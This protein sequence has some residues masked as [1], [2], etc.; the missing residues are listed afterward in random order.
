MKIST[1]KMW[2]LLVILAFTGVG[3]QDF[4]ATD[5]PDNELSFDEGIQTQQDLEEM[6]NSIYDVLANSLSGQGQKFAELLGQ[7]VNMVGN[8]GDDVQIYRRSTDFFNGSSGGWYRDPYFVIY[9]ANTL[10]EQIDRVGIDDVDRDRLVG[11]SY[12]LRAYAHLEL[13]KLFAQPY[14]YTDDN[15]H[16]GIVLRRATFTDPEPRSSVADVY[17][18]IIS[19]L[20]TARA[21]L[22]TLNPEGVRVD[23]CDVA[24]LLARVYLYQGQYAEAQLWANTAI[25]ESAKTLGAFG[26]RYVVGEQPQDALLY[27]VSTSLDDNRSGGWRGPFASDLGVPAVRA[28]FGISSLLADQPADLRRSTIDTLQD[29]GADVQVY[30]KYNML[31]FNSTLLSLTEMYYIEAESILRTSGDVN[32]AKELL[33]AIRLRNGLAELETNNPLVLLN[34]LLIDKRKEFLAEGINLWDLKRRGAIHGED[35]V[36][37]EA[38]WDCAGMVLQFPASE[39][40]VVG[41]ELNEEGGCN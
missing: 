10:I 16:P 19:D 40:T 23:G 36:I 5:L 25:T 38:P 13:V 39:I 34:E 26:T 4:L 41:F 37:R 32:R 24:A 30:T 27:I 7:D 15:S 3:C 6:V 2:G 11:E 22:P 17:D 1:C 9:R 31:V 33:N 21:S 12:A 20:L 28:D 14:G 8:V 18:L 35:V 29:A